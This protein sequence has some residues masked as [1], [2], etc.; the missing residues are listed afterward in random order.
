MQTAAS[1]LQVAQTAKMN[2]SLKELSQISAAQAQ[3]AH[4]NLIATRQ[5]SAGINI[6]TSLQ[7]ST[8]QEQQKIRIAQDEIAHLTRE[9]RKAIEDVEREIQELN[10][11]VEEGN[12]KAQ[13]LLIESKIQNALTQVQIDN[14]TLR[15]KIESNEKELSKLEKNHFSSMME[16]IYNAS[17]EI[18]EITKS[19]KHN[20]EIF[21]QLNSLIKGLKDTGVSTEKVDDLDTK[22]SIGKLLNQ[23]EM[24][25]KDCVNSFNMEESQ[26]LEDILD[27]LAHDEEGLS[28]ERKQK[29]EEDNSK[30]QAI[31]KKIKKLEENILKA[32]NEVEIL[33]PIVVVNE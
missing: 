22:A 3:I 19:D 20:I 25:M 26:D 21:F 17:E 2:K 10:K 13:E 15:F 6:M 18:K 5:V 8:L 1:T 30:I 9:T 23:T 33:R 12:K 28:A 16:V 11:T 31:N 14:D 32:Q 27:I 7:Q 24:A 29:I 4:E